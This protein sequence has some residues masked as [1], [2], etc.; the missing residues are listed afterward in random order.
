MNVP[1][2]LKFAIVLMAGILV[3]GGCG[4]YGQNIPYQNVAYLRLG[5]TS[6][7]QYPQMFGK[8]NAVVVQETA[9][10]KFEMV[11][12]LYISADMSTAY[13]RLLELEFRDGALN[14]YNYASSFEEDKTVVN[15]SN[16][17]EVKRG[18]SKKDDVLG[19]LGKPQGIARCPSCVPFYKDRCAKG[20]E[21]WSWTTMG[22]L[23][24]MSGTYADNEDPRIIS[25]VFDKDGVV[26]D[27][28]SVQVKKQ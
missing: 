15:A 19:L 16:F 21:V 10:G 13:S 18:V 4:H 1:Q 27:I 3:Q 17:E 26:T 14:S 11:Q 8:T 7:S 23:S 9:D 28:E 12:Y 20:I 5:Q 24:V 22:K 2:P 25:V 6:V